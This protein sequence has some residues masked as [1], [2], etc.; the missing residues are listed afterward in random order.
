VRYEPITTE[1][2][3]A[4][5]EYLVSREEMGRLEEDQ[6]T[7]DPDNFHECDRCKMYGEI[8]D[9]SR[10]LLNLWADEW[11]INLAWTFG[12]KYLPKEPTWCEC[13]HV[14]GHHG[15]DFPHRCACD[16][17]NDGSVCGCL[18]FKPSKSTAGEGTGCD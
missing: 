15:Y 10:P 6:C 1:A 14:S 11:A 9:Q 4:L 5:R 13:G 12:G 3:D 17:N 2:V 16:G 18:A 8:M 7:C